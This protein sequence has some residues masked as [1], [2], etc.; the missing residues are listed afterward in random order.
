MQLQL[1]LDDGANA[2]TLLADGVCV[3]RCSN[4]R[5]VEHYYELFSRTD[6][7]GNYR[8]EPLASSI[9]VGSNSS[10]E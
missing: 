6:Y 8:V 3:I 7:E 5:I 1:T 9:H 4:K 2:Y 10:R